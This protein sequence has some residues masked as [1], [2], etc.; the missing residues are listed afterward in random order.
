MLSPTGL[1]GLGAPTFV[2]SDANGF[3]L[4]A[5]IASMDGAALYAEATVAVI[6]A[7]I[8]CVKGSAE[9]IELT[10]RLPKQFGLFLI[11]KALG[12]SDFWS[13]RMDSAGEALDLE[14]MQLKGSGKPPGFGNSPVNFGGAAWAKI[15][16]DQRLGLQT[17]EQIL[18]DHTNFLWKVK[19][20]LTIFN[21]FN[22]FATTNDRTG[23]FESGILEGVESEPWWWTLLRNIG[24]MC[25]SG[26][27]AMVLL[28]NFYISDFIHTSFAQ[29]VVLPFLL[30]KLIFTMFFQS[31]EGVSAAAHTSHA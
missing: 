15:G 8:G 14:R 3:I 6:A 31:Y 2:N 16:H 19:T 11:L 23:D 22:V 9:V 10:D 17:K 5:P 4:K 29:T 1:N 28:A 24:D 21:P 12:Q 13:P 18:N 7:F 26:H 20:M 27:T 30:E 25:L